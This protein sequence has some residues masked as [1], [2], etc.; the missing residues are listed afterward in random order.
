[1]NY[2]TPIV[3]NSS[4]SVAQPPSLPLDETGVDGSPVP[5]NEHRIGSARI[6]DPAQRHGPGR[7]IGVQVDDWVAGLLD[8]V[9]AEDDRPV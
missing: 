5:G 7:R 1:M 3:R 2:V 9:S 8:K 6:E 4:H